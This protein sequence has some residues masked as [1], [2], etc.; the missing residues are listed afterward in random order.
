M[1]EKNIATMTITETEDG[2]TVEKD[3]KTVLLTDLT[4]AEIL[5]LLNAEADRNKHKPIKT[6]LD[7]VLKAENKALVKSAVETFVN[8]YTRDEA[9]F[10][11]AFIN[12]PYA[13][14]YKLSENEDA[15]DGEDVYSLK[16]SN[17][18]ILFSQV[19]KVYAEKHNGQTMAQAKNYVRMI[20]RFTHNLYLNECGGLSDGAGDKCAVIKVAYNGEKSE[21][22]VANVDFG[23]YS[24]SA[25]K[26]QLQAIVDTILP[27]DQSVPMVSADLNFVI[28]AYAK[29]DL[30]SGKVKAGAE[31]VVERI[32]F[33]A[34]RMRKNGIKYE[35]ESKAN[36]HKSKDDKPKVSERTE[37]QE[38]VMSK[39]PD[40]QHENEKP[41][42]KQTAVA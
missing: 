9:V 35:V 29:A 13:T 28:R 21:S 7:E 15:K 38:E 33:T 16:P 18:R 31:K 41:E 39:V 32:I 17:R 19:D 4:S 8:Q 27:A 25:M 10:W 36:C 22:K 6:A 23:K 20:A 37:K 24:K 5:A 3:S 42:G 14:I 34:V 11:T 26:A 30:D 12:T 2:L 40:R 1:N